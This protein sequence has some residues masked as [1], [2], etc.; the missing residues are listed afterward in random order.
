MVVTYDRNPRLSETERLDSLTTSIQL[1]LNEKA[2]K[3]T[4]SRTFVAKAGLL[5]I[6]Y[7]IGITIEMTD[8]AFAP[9]TAWG[10]AWEQTTAGKWHRIA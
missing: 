9:N 7:P 2:D 1:A 4:V 3:D 5:D 8:T 6:V 10:G